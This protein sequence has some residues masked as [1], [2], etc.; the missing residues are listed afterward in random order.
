MFMSD[1]HREALAHLTYGFGE[2]GGFALLTGEVGTGKTTVSRCLLEQLPDNTQLAFI[3]N[4]ALSAQELLATLCDELKIRYRKTGA[5]L[6]T[7]TDKIQEKLL[8]NHSD[9]LNTVLIIDE[10]QHLQA[11]VLEQLRLL[12]NLETNTK[13]LLQVILIGQPELQHLLQRQDLRQL[14]QRITARY[15]LLPLNKQEVDQYIKH[16]LDVAKCHRKLFSPTAVNKI[17][18]ITQGVPRLINLLCD[19]SLAIAYGNNA[20]LVDKKTV[21]LAASEIFGQITASNRYQNKSNYKQP[22]AW[23]T[24]AIISVF[25]ALYTGY[26]FA[27]PKD[28]ATHSFIKDE[29]KKVN[30]AHLN[31]TAPL[32]NRVMNKPLDEAEVVKVITEELPVDNSQQ[33]ANNTSAKKDLVSSASQVPKITPSIETKVEEKP[34]VE[35]KTLDIPTKEKEPKAT[36]NS[37]VKKTQ[38]NRIDPLVIKKQ[39]EALIEDEK[40]EQLDEQSLPENV[41]SELLALF[42]SAMEETNTVKESKGTTTKSESNTKVI[43]EMVKALT[44]MP[45]SFQNK[46]PH[47]NF[48]MH[49][50]ATDDS[51]WVKVNGDEKRQGDWVT[52]QVKLERIERADVVLNYQGILFSLPSLSTWD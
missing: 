41:S 45:E 24:L 18:K 27:Q 23:A 12:T 38:A 13:K 52:K 7:L 35:D 3:L 6:K 47:L 21:V 36:L 31:I 5:T 25:A 30:N 26:F 33:V 50:Y 28:I 22:L 32:E 29:N 14:A 49:I 34:S 40:T 48:E 16:R 19:R 39:K 1:R 2:T 46:I 8:K 17:H 43:A 15:H 37:P 4:P 51:G 42:K 9:G 44:D 10:A 20:S 11:E